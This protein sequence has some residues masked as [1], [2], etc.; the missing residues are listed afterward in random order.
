M[1]GG[2]PEGRPVAVVTGGGGGIGAAVAEELARTGHHVV[3]VDPLV[4]LDGSEQLP[5]PEE[6]TAGRIVASGGSARAS[7]LSVTDRHG[8]RALFAE[9]FAEHGRLDAVVNVAGITRPTSFARGTDDDWRAVL[10]VHLGGYLNILEAALAIMAPAGRGAV[11]GVTSGGGWRP[12]DAGAYS[13]AKRAVAALTWQ[14]G[15]C[16]PAGV[17][18][19]AMSPIAATR[20]VTA[21]LARAGGRPPSPARGS[22]SSSSSAT[23]GLSLSAM[24]SA[25]ELGPMGAHL[26]RSD[27]GWCRGQV[28][29]VGGS[30]IAVIDRPRLLEVFRTDPVASLA[31]LVSTASGALASAEA[32]QATSGGSNPRFAGLFD[33]TGE[34]R[35]PG[36]VARAA[37]VSDRADLARAVS[38]A[39]EARGID[40]VPIQH[41]EGLGGV[42]FTMASERVAAAAELRGP[43]DAVVV[44]PAGAS[45]A[46]A[47]HEWERVL[48]DHTDVPSGIHADAAW[49]RAVADYAA[50]A[51]RPVRVV[52]L[53]DATTAGGRSRAQASAQLARAGR[54]ATGERVSAFSV[55]LETPATV[56][57]E[58]RTIAEL[59]AHLA[60]ADDALGLAG[61][62]LVAGEGWLG[63]RGHPH[64]IGSITFGGP[65]VP[66]WLDAALRDIID[67]VTGPGGAR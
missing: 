19:N 39:L 9:L 67:P 37:V 40:C 27:R 30:E 17:S 20:M 21:A 62:E 28:I 48:A 11:L 53:T 4:S 25:E 12:A 16:V 5:A 15:R 58:V 52:T 35:A 56:T 22:S 65:A 14:L 26:A 66:P 49:T 63:L 6:T 50:R 24:P 10:D 33:A 29:F 60:T 2:A 7:S 43:L 45:A 64:P 59:V 54:G 51:D 55:N 38:A 23:G 47:E 46:A 31:H 61:A 57:D 32:T 8:I 41:D 13:C 44:A 1:A 3:T 34:E 42:T 18:V 36:G